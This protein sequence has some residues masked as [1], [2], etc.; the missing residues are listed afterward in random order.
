M[1]Y[2]HASVKKRWRSYFQ[3]LLNTQHPCRFLHDLL[4]NLKLIAPIT[5]DETRN[6]LRRMKN[7]KAI[8]LADIP[9]EAWKSLGSL[10]VPFE[11]Y[12]GHWIDTTPVAA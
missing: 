8:G 4:I 2:S 9:I 10:G 7:G 12:L 11:V 5:L 3:E 6:C 1:L